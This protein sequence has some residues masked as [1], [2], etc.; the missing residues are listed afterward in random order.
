[1]NLFPDIAEQ[2]TEEKLSAL[3]ELF[4]RSSKYR[5]SKEYLEL[6]NFINRFPD[7]S[8]FNAFLIHMQNSGVEI[9][10]TERKWKSNGRRIKIGSRPMVI[11][12]PFG[13]VSFVYDIADTDGPD[14]PEA[15][16]NPF[17]TRGCL[18]L[19]VYENT[20]NNSKRHKI[21]IEERVL[22]NNL[23][24]FAVNEKNLF[25]ITI[26][27][28][29]GLNEKYSTLIHELG[30]VFSGHLG[31]NKFSWWKNRSSKDKVVVEIEAESIAYL[32]CK[33]LGLETSSEAY[34]SNYVQENEKMLDVSLDTILTVSGY[35]EQMRSSLFNPK[36][37]R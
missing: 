4:L 20:K 18:N 35:I 6:I 28:H 7:L 30:H 24:G 36:K 23:G 1:M 13:P 21:K 25:K 10:K 11:L 15:I 34:L 2:E 17:A 8:P 3:D 31:I 29:S 12:I 33:R 16:Y 37:P 9:V 32:V 22:H 19:R 27:N 5:N 26:N 14:L